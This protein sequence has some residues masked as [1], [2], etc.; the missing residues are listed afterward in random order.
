M[1]KAD[2][3]PPPGTPE[4]AIAW[5]KSR[6]PVGADALELLSAAARRKAFFVS[7]VAQAA[8]VN[9]V[10]VEIER[11]LREGTTL[12]DFKQ[13]VGAKLEDSWAGT[14]KAPAARLE[15]IFRTNVQ[16]AYNAGRYA[17]ATDP[18]TKKVRPFWQFDAVVDGRTTPTCK[19]ANGVVLDADDPWWRSHIPPLHF[20]CRSTFHPL[21]RRQAE[22]LGVA[23]EAPA[24]IAD[25]GFGQ[26]PSSAEAPVAS[27]SVSLSPAQILR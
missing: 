26:P 5:L 13:L 3:P 11:A 15:T 19:R 9:D 2:V 27:P 10:H 12:E 25:A 23:T 6:V 7:G 17:Q 4:E 22:H 21:T 14:V 8:L 20:N 1:P 16:G 18:D 24:H